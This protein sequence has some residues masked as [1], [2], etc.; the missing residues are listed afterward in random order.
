MAQKPGTPEAVQADVAA[1]RTKAV[2][3]RLEGKTWQEIADALG[4]PNRGAA[5]NDVS[6]ALAQAR[7]ELAQSAEDFREMEL[8]RLDALTAKVHEV[9]ER[10]HVVVTPGGKIVYDGD[11]KLV[12]DGPT[13]AAIDRLV[14]IGESRRKL[15][16]L[17]S[18]AK[19]EHS[20]Q[21]LYAVEGVNVEKLT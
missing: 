7:E 11:V 20:G 12:D 18:P 8:Q 21:V 17:D 16:G 6:R 13:L 3:M 4:L 9:L 19:V 15:L 10:Q 1:R 2:K 5:Y 14:K